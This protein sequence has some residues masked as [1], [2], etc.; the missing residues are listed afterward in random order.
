MDTKSKLFVDRMRDLRRYI[1]YQLH[2][3]HKEND[4]DSEDYYR[5]RLIALNHHL[6]MFYECFR[7]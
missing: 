2:N 6:K 3:A 5:I 4:Y 1:L 7:N